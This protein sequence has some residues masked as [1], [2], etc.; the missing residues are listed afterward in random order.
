MS[1]KNWNN[2]LVA[3]GQ[4][5]YRVRIV[6]ASDEAECFR[7]WEKLRNIFWLDRRLCDKCFWVKKKITISVSVQDKTRIVIKIVFVSEV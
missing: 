1:Y 6:T 3:L 4:N 2:S 5:V 7:L